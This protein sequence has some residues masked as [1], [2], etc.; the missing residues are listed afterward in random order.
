AGGVGGGGR[1]ALGEAA[2]PGPPQVETAALLHVD[3]AVDHGEAGGSL[4][5][6]DPEGPSPPAR[7]ANA[8]VVSGS[9]GAGH[10]VRGG[11]GDRTV[12]GGPPAPAG[13]GPTRGGAGGAAPAGARPPPPHPP[14]PRAGPS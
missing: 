4:P 14:P 9:G 8:D 12:G 7:V 3:R 1:G 13:G 5:L 2:R 11:D 6:H 10:A